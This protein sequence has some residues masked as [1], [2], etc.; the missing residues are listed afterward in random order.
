ML[1]GVGATLPG[2]VLGVSPPPLNQ[3]IFSEVFPGNPSPNAGQEFIEL[4]NN[5]SGDIN[6]AG[7][8]VQYTS[9]SKTDW[10]SPSRNVALSGTVLAGDY[11]LLASTNYLSDKSQLSFSATLSQTGGHLRILDNNANLQDLIGWGNAAMPLGTAVTAPDGGSSLSRLTNSEGFNLSGDNSTDWL[12]SLSATPAADNIITLPA[13]DDANSDSTGTSSTQLP[14]SSPPV[15]IGYPEIDISE[16]LPNPASPQTDANDEYVEL[17]NP[18]DFDVDLTGFTL[19]TGITST[20]KY[21]INN[22]IIPAGGY[23]SFYSGG[24]SLSLSNTSGKVQLLNPDGS[25]ADETDIYFKAPDGQAWIF[26][27]GIW[28]WTTMPTPSAA[29][30]LSAPVVKAASATKKT[31]TK[32]KAAKKIT[33]KT[34]KAKKKSTPATKPLAEAPPPVQT[35]LHPLV[36]AGVGSSAL[37]YAMY[38]YRTDLAGNVYRLRRNRETW[39][40]I[41]KGSYA[42]SLNRTKGRLRRWQNHIRARL[43]S[44]LRK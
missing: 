33:V 20:H 40:A 13:S 16:L 21:V 42:P 9:A 28:V 26:A 30:I 23:S 35:K 7:W 2:K 36:L 5:T 12:V 41:W 3:I 34:A 6:L 14:D 39:G 37:A 15:T 32:V 18:N 38:E 31:T 25:L 24:T 10:T 19:I 17:Y 29:N 11:Y 4:Y 22:V 8:H 44:R 27:D 43:S 1:F